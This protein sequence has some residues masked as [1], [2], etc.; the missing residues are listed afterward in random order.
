MTTT[1]PRVVRFTN[2]GRYCEILGLLV[3]ETS[4]RIFYRR[5]PHGP[6]FVISKRVG[7]IE[8]C[9]R[10]PDRPNTFSFKKGQQT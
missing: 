9:A 3:R 8:P 2:G 4:T 1:L 6:E 7:H 10:C 5:F